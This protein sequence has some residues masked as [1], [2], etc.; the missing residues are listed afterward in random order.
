M[1]KLTDKTSFAVTLFAIFVNIFVSAQIYVL[2]EDSMHN[3]TVYNM[4]EAIGA[5]SMGFLSDKF[6]RRKTNIISHSI[7][8]LLLLLIFLHPNYLYAI[9]L[10]GFFYSPLPILRAG[11]VDN[12]TSFPRL[13]LL[14]LSFVVQFIPWC[15]YYVYVNANPHIMHSLAL[16]LLTLS[17]L[18]SIFFFHDKRDQNIAE[19]L[20]LKSASIIH[21]SA[22]KRVF[23][24]FIAFFLM[25]LVF[26]FSDNF[27]E[28]IDDMPNFYSLMS[29]GTAI[30]VLLALVFKDI[31]HTSV[32]RVN[33]GINAAVSFLPLLAVIFFSSLHF[34]GAFQVIMLSSFGAMT[35]PFVYDI[36][37]HSVN[38]NYRG[39]ASGILDFVYN[40]ASLFSLSLITLL[41]MHKVYTY[42]IITVGLCVAVFF[43]TKSEKHPEI[44]KP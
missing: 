15:F 29:I 26:F 43:Q 16:A 17:L 20:R 24:T 12:F 36:T 37:M 7:G 28:S 8:V 21:S 25:Q 33:Y 22:R 9:F 11:L 32:L 27:L 41:D 1:I 31:S 5:I 34:N 14:M 10:L 42:A 38:A 4:M 35:L 3:T 18:G 40:L 44:A 2:F 23:F 30:C 6:C 39:T 13:Y 19:K